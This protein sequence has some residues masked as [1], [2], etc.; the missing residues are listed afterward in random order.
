[1]RLSKIKIDFLLTLTDDTALLQHAKYSIPSKKQGYTTDDNARALIACVKHFSLFGKSD[2]TKELIEKYLGFLLYMQKPDGTMHNWLG[3]DRK[4]LDEL[5]SEDCIG[6]TIWACG[7]CVNSKLPEQLRMLSREIFDRAFKTTSKFTA[8]RAKAFALM[9]LYHYRKAY[10]DDKN[11]PPNIRILGDQLARQ[12]EQESSKQ[13]EWFEQYVTYANARL[14]QS[15]FLAYDSIREPKLLETAMKSLDF[16]IRIQSID[17]IF[18]PIGNQGWF[19]KEGPRAF[20]DQQS[21]EAASMTEASIAA[22]LVTHKRKYLHAANQAFQWFF[23]QNTKHLKV[24]DPQDGS[25]YDGITKHGLN[26][27]KGAEST[28]SFLQARIAIEEKNYQD[29]IMNN[30]FRQK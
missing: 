20:Y 17:N 23:G 21:V 22:Y 28:V 2:L 12:F 4:Y 30:S 5:G 29:K 10:A 9:G 13:W 11:V 3:Y 14:P 19:K 8:P 7:E 6:R 16:L 27:N 15:L 18:V 26:L 24:Y 1:V 25:C